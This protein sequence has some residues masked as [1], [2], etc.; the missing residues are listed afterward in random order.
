[1]DDARGN[2]QSCTARP[3]CGV[4]DIVAA[5]RRF[6]RVSAFALRMKTGA[7]IGLRRQ[8]AEIH[9]RCRKTRQGGYGNGIGRSASGC[10]YSF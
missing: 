8:P 5:K 6:R 9:R 1:M 4:E 3:S 7:I 2:V 10:A